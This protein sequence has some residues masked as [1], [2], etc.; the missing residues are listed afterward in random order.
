MGSSKSKVINLV[1]T[2]PNPWQG[3][4]KQEI[5]AI[6]KGAWAPS[7]DDFSAVA[8][9]SYLV[10]HFYQLLG[11]VLQQPQ[12]SVSRV[13]ILT[14]SN[15]S[16]IAFKGTINP[17]STFAEVLL[18]VPSALSLQMLQKMTPSTW[19]QVGQSKKK[20]TVADIRARFSKDA[21]VFFYSCKSATDP[22]LL[23]EFANTFQVTA[24]G[25][26]DNIC[27][28]PKYSANRI[29]RKHVGIG[30]KCS[31][32]GANFTAVDKRGVERKPKP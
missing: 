26:K 20:Y 29:D 30:S 16:L 23:Q 5:A 13:N 31:E 1:T 32:K 8:P 10:D 2:F 14:H 11:V 22:Q 25:F 7:S 19:F 27:F 15:P 12:G 9:S 3:K 17:R 28:C 6:A 21:K 24:V 4:I 18:N